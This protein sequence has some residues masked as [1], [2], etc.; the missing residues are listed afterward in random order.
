MSR[1]QLE[2]RKRQMARRIDELTRDKLIIAVKS[3]YF[4]SK[5]GMEFTLEQYEPKD[6][7]RQAY[8]DL[9]G[10]EKNILATNST[11]KIRDLI[12]QVNRLNWRIRWNSS[13][14]IR[15]FFQ[16]W[17]MGVLEN[18][19][20]LIVRVSSSHK[21]NKRLRQSKTINSGSLSTN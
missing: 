1:F 21:A 8:G 3:E 13:R 19:H 6:T 14:Y 20:N 10:Q 11:M 17:L 5:R 16:R 9:L 2:D 7:D 4:D 15:E 18:L 12:D